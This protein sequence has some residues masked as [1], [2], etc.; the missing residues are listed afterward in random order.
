MSRA[1]VQL[2][3][4][5]G[6]VPHGDQG[7]PGI[8]VSLDQGALGCP[9]GPGVQRN[10]GVRVSWGTPGFPGVS[11]GIRVLQGTLGTRLSLGIPGSKR[12]NSWVMRGNR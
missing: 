2:A 12:G 4:S 10:S 11:A 9:W 8:K 6:T 3:V 5:A 1:L 7:A